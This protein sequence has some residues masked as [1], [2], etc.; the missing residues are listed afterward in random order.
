MIYYVNGITTA[1]AATDAHA[2]VNIWNP[3]ATR[4]IKLVELAVNFRAG[5]P[6]GGAGFVT[7][8][9][10]TIGTPAAAV[11][12]VAANHSRALATP[13]SAF[14]LQMGAFSGQPTLVAG[15]LYPMWAFPAVLA[16]G[17]ILPIPR[18]IEIPPGQGLAFVNIAA[19]AF[20]A[21]E[22][23]FVIEEA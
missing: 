8:R 12:L 22:W 23:G 2:I 13:D 10:S 16:T 5:A 4:P 21:S 20:A 18:G 7:R 15:E 1:T 11:A 14:A 6:T 3:S 19:V 17:L 9:T